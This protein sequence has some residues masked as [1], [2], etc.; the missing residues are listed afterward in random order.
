VFLHVRENQVL[1]GRYGI[2]SIPVQAF[3]DANGQEVFRHTGF[4]AEEAVMKQL[5]EMGVAQ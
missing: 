5:K 3:F 2:Q 4:F 1:A